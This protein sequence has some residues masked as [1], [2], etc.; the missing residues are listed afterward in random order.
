MWKKSIITITWTFLKC[1]DHF[2][3]WEWLAILLKPASI[4]NDT[5]QHTKIACTKSIRTK[6][7]VLN[8]F[9]YMPMFKSMLVTINPSMSS[10]K[11]SLMWA[12][13]NG[14]SFFAINA[15][16][17]AFQSRDT[18]SMQCK[19]LTSIYAHYRCFFLLKHLFLSIFF[20]EFC[21]EFSGELIVHGSRI[22]ETF[23]GDH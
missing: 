5:L 18:L 17:V 13:L 4:V 2:F 1:R 10:L 11:I 8:F 16:S 19:N 23:Q 15:L 6:L 7:I 21:D 22:Y 3:D 12:A 14:C 20:S 9:F